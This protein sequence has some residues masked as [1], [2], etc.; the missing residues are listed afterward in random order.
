M[1]DFECKMKEL[2]GSLS[3]E[4]R[5]VFKLV[6]QTEHQHRFTGSRQE[7]PESF[8]RAALEQA[9]LKLANQADGPTQYT[10]GDENED[11]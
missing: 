9:R 11:K 10:P 2:S 4:A 8:A 3:P 1:T 6:L 7:L 5:I